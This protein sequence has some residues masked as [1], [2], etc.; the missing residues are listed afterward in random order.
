MVFQAV[1]T[2]E[3]MRE[4]SQDSAPLNTKVSGLTEKPVARVRAAN[5]E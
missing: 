3:I 2:N 1:D 5:V 4:E